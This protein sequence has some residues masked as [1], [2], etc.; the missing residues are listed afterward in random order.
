MM[1]YLQ[2]WMS[3]LLLV[4]L[5]ACRQDDHHDVAG[6]ASQ[7]MKVQ[8]KSIPIELSF[9]STMAPIHSQTVT[10]RFD[11]VLTKVAFHFGDTVHKDQVLFG[12]VS[13]QLASDFRDHVTQ[14]LQSKNDYS[15]AQSK[16]RGTEQLYQHDIIDRE[17]Y[18]S[19]KNTLQTSLLG[20]LNHEQSL[21][22]FMQTLP[23]SDRADVRQLTL[24]DTDKIKAILQR[25]VATLEVV[26]PANGVALLVDKEDA[27]T[28]TLGASVKK[29]ANLLEIGDMSGLLLS[30]NVPEEQIG[31]VKVGS[32][33]EVTSQA[34]P[35]VSMQGRVQRVGAQAQV[36]ES[37]AVFPATVV[38]PVLPHAA[39]NLVRVGM[40]AQVAMHVTRPAAL[41][42]PIKAVVIHD[43]HKQV[44]V[45]VQGKQQ[46]VD[47]DTGATTQDLVEV[48]HGLKDGQEIV[49]PK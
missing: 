46:W 16:F 34:L 14:Y 47:I 18:E 2:L 13:T 45:M 31:T 9:N 10:S 41:Y 23:V 43:G 22:D 42:I 11:G 37:G 3:V 7:T 5:G 49:V 8:R 36:D 1:R 32:H 12:M 17:S 28:V 27:G 19:E 25:P 33:V 6:G 30:F 44:A 20:Y 40:T 24:Q 39:V 21:I 35:G 38:V 26:A 48:T 15:V 4:S 29:D